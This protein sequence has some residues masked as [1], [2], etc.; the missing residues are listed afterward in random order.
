VTT[1]TPDDGLVLG[2][3]FGAEHVTV[4]AGFYP[5]GFKHAAGLGEIAAELAVEGGS[6]CDLDPFRV[7]R[8]STEPGPDA[9]QPAASPAERALP[10]SAAR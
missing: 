10:V 1:H 2:P 5:H 7:E 8:F 9:E 3:L 6:L 4:K